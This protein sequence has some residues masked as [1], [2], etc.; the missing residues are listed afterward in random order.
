MPKN[1]HREIIVKKTI[2]RFIRQ[3]HLYETV[4]CGGFIRVHTCFFF[5]RLSDWHQRKIFS[6]R[7][8]AELTRILC[9]RNPPRGGGILG[10]DCGRRFLALPWYLGSFLRQNEF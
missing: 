9:D 10:Q 6:S 1:V 8:L 3:H 4:Q 5:L 7:F 2:G